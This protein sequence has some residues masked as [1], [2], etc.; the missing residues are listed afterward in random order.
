MLSYTASFQDIQRDFKDA[1]IPTDSPGFY[2]HPRFIAREQANADFLN[3]YARFVQA[4]N[5]TEDYLA[6]ASLII[7]AATRAIFEELT[8]DGRE[9]ACVDT[10]GVLSKSLERHGIWNF[11]VKGSLTITYPARAGISPQY[12][13]TLDSGQYTAPHAWLFAPPFAIVDATLRHQGCSPAE[14]CHLPDVVLADSFD[15]VVA[16]I[17][18][19]V[20]P[21]V[22]RHFISKGYSIENELTQ[23]VEFMTVFPAVET[24]VGE[25]SLKYFPCAVSAPDVELE[26]MI[27]LSSSPRRAITIYHESIRPAIQTA[28]G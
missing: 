4:R 10:S 20:S 18:D 17:K 24:L 16:T 1:D 13:Y 6:R 8:R 23:Y 9:G 12:F 21:E 25:T 11:V 22:R 26:D 27:G 28:E 2:N 14:L 15:P 7:P 3:N 19:L 5:Y